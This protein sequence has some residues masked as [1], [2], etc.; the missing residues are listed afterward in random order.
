[1]CIRDRAKTTNV[2]KQLLKECQA[3]LAAE[4]IIP[5][6]C[7]SLPSASSRRDYYNDLKAFFGFMADMGVQPFHVTG[8]HVRLYKEALVQS[9]KKSATIARALSVIRGAYEQ[10]GKKGL[11]DWECVGDIQAVSSPRVEKNTCLLYTSPSPRDR[12]RSR[13]PSSA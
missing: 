3:N 6:F 2:L 10:F 5:W 11:V 7:D 4:A 13:M 9:N 12:T 1:M 8:D